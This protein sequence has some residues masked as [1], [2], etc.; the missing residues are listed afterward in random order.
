M[1]AWCLAEVARL[2]WWGRPQLREVASRAARSERL[3]WRHGRAWLRRVCQHL[4][5]LL[6]ESGTTTRHGACVQVCCPLGVDG[7]L[8]SRVASESRHPSVRF[9]SQE[10]QGASTSQRR[11]GGRDA[12]RLWRRGHVCGAAPR[13]DPGC[14]RDPRA[15]SVARG[16]RTVRA[17][18]RT[19]WRGRPGG[20][21]WGRTG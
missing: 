12:V 9:S 20:T 6:L 10:C 17:G 18:T 1:A 14:R 2:G 21:G 11:R 19:R 7:R 5:L 4:R 3:S 13:G 16:G 15:S 8:R